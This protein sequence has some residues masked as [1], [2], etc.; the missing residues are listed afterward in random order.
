MWEEFALVNPGRLSTLGN[1]MIT[2][3]CI[4]GSV[5]VVVLTNSYP[6]EW[7]T[8]KL[9][10]VWLVSVV[11]MFGGV[12]LIDLRLAKRKWRFIESP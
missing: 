6:M 11:A 12:S 8:S 5:A 9:N 7:F 2:L 10:I 3:V 4:L 1:L